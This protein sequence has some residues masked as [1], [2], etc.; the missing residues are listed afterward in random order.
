[1]ELIGFHFIDRNIKSMIMLQP[2]V[3][4]SPKVYISAQPPKKA[5][6]KKAVSQ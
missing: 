2:E 1:M 3:N 5:P 6:H 4:I